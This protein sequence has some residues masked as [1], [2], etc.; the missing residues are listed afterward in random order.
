MKK[1]LFSLILVVILF[2]SVG[3]YIFIDSKKPDKTP[4][5]PIHEFKIISG[6]SKKEEKKK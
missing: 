3:L 4:Q 1:N 5:K 2:A 6:L